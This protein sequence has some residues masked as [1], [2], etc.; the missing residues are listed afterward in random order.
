M[1]DVDWLTAEQPP[2]S[3]SLTPGAVDGVV[4]GRGNNS[5]TVSRRASSNMHEL[6]YARARRAGPG[7]AVRS[8]LPI[9]PSTLIDASPSIEPI[10]NG[11]QR[12]HPPAFPTFATLYGVASNA[13]RFGP[14]RFDMIRYTGN[15]LLATKSWRRA[16]LILRT[17]PLKWENKEK[18]GKKQNRV[19]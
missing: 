5:C 2:A 8:F 14:V 7:R 6:R 1:L 13:L 3:D 16:S 9:I 15:R 11:E 17:V 19:A 4:G 12:P 10:I 18:V